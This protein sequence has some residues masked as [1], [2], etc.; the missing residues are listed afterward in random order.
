MPAAKK[1]KRPT[2]V[3]VVPVGKVATPVQCNNCGYYTGDGTVG[4]PCPTC[5]ETLVSAVS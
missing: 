2:V 1:R 3:P 4:A 5:K